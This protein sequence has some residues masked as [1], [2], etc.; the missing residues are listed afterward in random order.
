[1][2]NL[3]FLQC[4]TFNKYHTRR[5]NMIYNMITCARCNTQRPHAT[6]RNC[7]LEYF[8]CYNIIRVTETAFKASKREKKENSENNE[9]L[10][11]E[12]WNGK[13]RKLLEMYS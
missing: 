10:Y 3:F 7:T 5:Y 9:K 6:T 11:R 4:Y 8:I 2:A 13:R 12:I 1:M